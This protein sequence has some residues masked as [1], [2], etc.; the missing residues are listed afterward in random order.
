MR[1][2]STLKEGDLGS[3]L[4]SNISGG[5]VFEHCLF[6]E[7][8]SLSMKGLFLCAGIFTFP[9]IFLEVCFVRAW[10][11]DFWRVRFCGRCNFSNFNA[12]FVVSAYL[13]Y[14]VKTGW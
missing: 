3:R 10:V 4:T 6:L 11:Y 12:L 8:M 2:R 13:G 7:G 1:K 14:T 5:S 9:G